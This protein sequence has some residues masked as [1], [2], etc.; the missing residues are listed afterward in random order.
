VEA[1]TLLHELRVHQIELELQNEELRSARLEMERALR[2]YTELFD[3]APIGY[4]SLG[5]DHVIQD[6]NRAGVQLLGTSRPLLRGRPIESIVA[7]HS[8]IRLRNLLVSAE[9]NPGRQSCELELLRTGSPFAARLGATILAHSEPK[10]LIAFEDISLSKEREE[11]LARTERALRAAARHKDEFLAVLSHELRNPLAP[12]KNSV[13]VLQRSDPTS[14]AAR[15]AQQIIDRQVTHLTRL[16]DDLLDVTRIAKGKIQLQFEQ[17][18]L[19]GLLQRTL[20]DQLASFEA[21]GVALE[22]QLGSQATWVR[23]DAARLVQIAT[24]VL[25]NALKFTP[26]LGRVTLTLQR[27]RERCELQI[28][29]TGVGIP[30]EVL[31][32]VF[33]P[34]AQAPQTLDRARGGLGLGL[35]MVKGLVELHGGQV[36]IESTGLGQG[37]RVSVSLPLS[38]PPERQVF[39]SQAAPARQRQ[40]V[41]I[42][43]DNLDA[44][45]MLKVALDLTG[46]QVRIAHDG[47]RGLELAAEFDPD[48]VICDIGLPGMD[49]YQVARA[50]R[51]QPALRDVFLVALSGYAQP[52]DLQRAR[53]A[54]FDR[55]LA[56]PTSVESLERVLSDPRR[57]PPP[58]AHSAIAC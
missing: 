5:P 44:C 13:F 57:A 49:G 31:A 43:E 56:K 55:H 24:N 39:E 29:D 23:A 41:L 3:F 50:F 6:V 37:T 33:E 38:H 35:A 11:R 54:G 15:R 22:S 28:T 17:V 2:S 20:E 25:T 26:R 36:R 30:A 34:F 48:V 46:H 1:N 9:I 19:T 53:D 27:G 51:A 8:Q 12:I 32:R 58:A 47:A 45:E 42:I 40:R 18:E 52:E 4:A 21:M 16:V 14:D 7:Q 10:T